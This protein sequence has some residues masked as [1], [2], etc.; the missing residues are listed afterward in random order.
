MFVF[1]TRVTET[2]I[3][4]AVREG[5]KLFASAVKVS[6][7]LVISAVRVPVM[8]LRVWIAQWNRKCNLLILSVFRAHL[9]PLLFNFLKRL[10]SLNV[11]DSHYRYSGLLLN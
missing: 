9:I 1:A 6:L 5:C 10:R 4:K 2:D 7:V 8:P 3:K 11:N